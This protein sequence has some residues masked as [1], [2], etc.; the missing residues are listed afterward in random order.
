[1]TV[2]KADNKAVK[3]IDHS[4]CYKDPETKQVVPNPSWLKSDFYADAWSV[5]NGNDE[6]VVINFKVI[7]D[8]SKYLTD[9]EFGQFLLTI[10]LVLLYARTMPGRSIAGTGEVQRKLAQNLMLIARY[11]ILE[12]CSSFSDLTKYHI[13]KFK[14]SIVYGVAYTLSYVD[15]FEYYVGKKDIH[16]PKKINDRWR[17]DVID[18]GLLLKLIGIDL[19]SWRT[20]HVCVWTST[21]YQHDKGMHVEQ[22]YRYMLE[23]S[24]PE[25]NKLRAGSLRKIYQALDLLY[26]L[27]GG[28][29]LLYVNGAVGLSVNPFQNATPYKEAKSCGSK[30][31]RTKTIPVKLAMHLLDRSVRWVLDYGYELLELRD[32]A[33]QHRNY[34]LQDITPDEHYASKLMRKWLFDYVPKNT[35]PAQPWPISGYRRNQTDET[36]PSLHVALNN[37]LPAAC[38]VVLATFLARRETELLLTRWVEGNIPNHWGCFKEDDEGLWIEQYVEKT[39]RDWDY[40]P[41]NEVVTKAIYLLRDWSSSARAETGT[42]RLFQAHTLAGNIQYFVSKDLLQNFADFVE[43]PSDDSG[44]KWLFS[45]HQFRRMF[46]MLYLHRFEL[47]DLQAL[48]YHLRHFGLSMTLKYVREVVGGDVFNE[49][50]RRKTYEV[51][52]SI[53]KGEKTAVGPMAPQVEKLVRRIKKHHHAKIQVVTERQLEGLLSRFLEKHEWIFIPK[54]YGGCFGVTKHRQRYAKCRDEKNNAHP[55]AAEISQCTKCPNYMLVADDYAPL[56]RNQLTNCQTISRDKQRSSLISAWA[57]SRGDELKSL[58]DECEEAI[59]KKAN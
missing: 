56:L 3:N 45:D 33:Q 38:F 51:F 1:M 28:D 10:K 53:V 4:Q 57:E 8:S 44:Q 17:K 24:K 34:I 43:V 42:N 48:S 26:D 13:E 5:V 12:G 2:M 52:S 21:K 14:E 18:L 46:A 11:A 29:G 31:E 19:N 36:R 20:D 7:V 16:L 15:R 40:F 25:Y 41:V 27:A 22:K 6:N 49:V 30:G 55:E 9:E 59:S 23:A 32:C 39:L 37:H 47:G 50:S 54:P 58:L 35:G